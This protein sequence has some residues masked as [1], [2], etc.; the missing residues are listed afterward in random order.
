MKNTDILTYTDENG[1]KFHFP[2]WV[3]LGAIDNLSDE[4]KRDFAMTIV[5]TIKSKE[6]ALSVLDMRCKHCGIFLGFDGV[7]HCWND[8]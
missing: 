5:N 6:L 3:V 2:T 4:D 8:E 1:F 7:C